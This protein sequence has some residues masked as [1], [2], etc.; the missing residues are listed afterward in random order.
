M[1]YGG[2][3]AHK[4]YLTL[5]VVNRDGEVVHRRS[6]IPI[7]AG[8]PLLEELSEYRPLKV[9]VETCPFW[10]WIHDLVEPTEIEFHLAHASRLEAIARAKTKTDSVDA[11]LLARMLQGDLIPKAYPKPLAQRESAR[12]IRHRATMVKDRTRCINRIHNQ[13][14]QRGIQSERESLLLRKGRRWLETTVWPQLAPQ[15]RALVRS[16]LELVDLLSSKIKE[17][18]KQIQREAANHPAAALLQTIPGVGPY[19]GLLFAAELLPIQRFES[20]GHLVSY[21]GLAPTVKQSGSGEPRHGPI[22]RGA[23]RWVRGAMIS[24]I[25]NH[26]QSAPDSP[27]ASYYQELK[28]RLGWPT[29]RVAAARKLCRIVYAMLSTGEVW[30]A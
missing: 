16:Q 6:R 25:P 21:S 29:A 17:L 5:A 18:D 27:V 26:L 10:P 24:T 8:E 11:E 2:I 19:R 1:Y 22:P 13:L 9:V 30:R 23:N 4:S 20:A 12:L 7:G 28:E 3:D 15:Q 14:H